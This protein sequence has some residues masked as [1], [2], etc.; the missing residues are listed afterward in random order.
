MVKLEAA[1]EPDESPEVDYF[2]DHHFLP[3]RL[4]S[5]PR[6]IIPSPLM[7]ERGWSPRSEELKRVVGDVDPHLNFRIKHLFFYSSHVVADTWSSPLLEL[8]RTVTHDDNVT[9]IRLYLDE[10]DVI[11]LNM[12]KA[13][14]LLPMGRPLWVQCDLIFKKATI[15]TSWST[16]LPELR[17]PTSD[18]LYFGI[19]D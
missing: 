4:R 9:V 11:S 15:H 16:N 18:C 2:T 7:R 5:S 14:P 3:V 19:N 10:W 6:L 1:A 17:S 13:E 12:G 8:W